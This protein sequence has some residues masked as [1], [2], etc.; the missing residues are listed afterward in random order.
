[1]ENN[2]IIQTQ[3]KNNKVSFN[4]KIRSCYSLLKLLNTQYWNNIG[5]WFYDFIFSVVFTAFF[6]FINQAS[7]KLDGYINANQFKNVL[8]GLITLEVISAGTFSMPSSIME[9]K[10]SILMKRIGSTPIKQWMFIATTFFYYFLINLLITIWMFFWVFIMFGFQTYKFENSNQLVKGYQLLFGSGSYKIVNPGPN[11]SEIASY[12]INWFGM[13]ISLIYMNMISIFIGLFNLSTSKT[14][15]A[16]NT[17]GT[18]LYF[19]SMLLSGMLFPLSIVTQNPVLNGLSYITPYRY[20]NALVNASWM[21]V[22][23]FNPYA[24]QYSKVLNDIS[25]T[26][27][28]LVISF[29]VPILII[30]AS[31]VA[32]I[33][34]FRWSTR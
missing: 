4:V 31:V 21:N 16:L 33:K 28:D 10:T 11:Q 12:G 24:S 8:I 17:K 3:I 9:I 15:T 27:V 22:D 2:N 34:M 14:V 19:A 20:S 1:M 25:I 18:M 6:G 32:M 30:S 26:P 23:I 7:M 13:V 29:I 5:E